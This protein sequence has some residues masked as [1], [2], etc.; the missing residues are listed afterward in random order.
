VRNE[1]IH[2]LDHL[3][4]QHPAS[5]IVGQLGAKMSFFASPPE[6]TPDGTESSRHHPNL[7]AE[8]LDASRR[9]S[10]LRNASVSRPAPVASDAR[11]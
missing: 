1:V 9:S 11:S 10:D 6:K 3:R 5:Q 8:C 4:R 7:I 2:L